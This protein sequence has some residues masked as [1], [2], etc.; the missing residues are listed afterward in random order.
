MERQ[1]GQYDGDGRLDTARRPILSSAWGRATLVFSLMGI[2]ALLGVPY[3]VRPPADTDDGLSRRLRG[4]VFRVQDVAVA[5]AVLATGAMPFSVAPAFRGAVRP[6]GLTS[7]AVSPAT[8]KG[9]KA[10]VIRA[11][12]RAQAG[13]PAPIVPA[14]S[15]APEKAVPPE[16][17][18]AAGPAPATDAKAAGE[19]YWVQV[20]AYKDVEVARRVA[21]RLREQNYPVFESVL[22]RGAAARPI[23]LAPQPA[24]AAPS[25]GKSDRYE[26]LV[27]G[28]SRAEVDAQISAKG[29]AA[30]STP[31]GAVITPSLPLREA[32]A[33]ARD[34]SGSGITVRVRRVGAPEPAPAGAAAPGGGAGPGAE[35]LYRVR[36]G[37]YADRAAAVAVLQELESKGY[38]PFL[39][40]GGE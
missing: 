21:A 12:A 31:E 5:P 22:T 1:Y 29:L 27:S 20:G 39:G 36:V 33:L 18:D 2:V 4:G 6:V 32:V 10:R 19:R 17:K 30:R 7:R 14:P 16:K 11:R 8:S 26:V 24:A 38:K 40:R 3:A 15:A 37:G 35:T 9:A 13:K 23:P 34:L 28:P 25:A